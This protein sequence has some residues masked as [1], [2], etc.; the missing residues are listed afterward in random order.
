LHQALQAENVAYVV[1]PYEADAQMAYL[2]K[3]GFVHGIITEDSDL[4]VFGCKRVIFKLDS[5]GDC[6]C[7]RRENFARVTEVPL[8]NWTDKQ[9]REMA[10]SVAHCI[11]VSYS[12]YVV[13]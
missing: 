13:A 8:H 6:I 1:A 3:A 4:L 9:F 2:E 10:V 11:G 12:E 7:I 5:N